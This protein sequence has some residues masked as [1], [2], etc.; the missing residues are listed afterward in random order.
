M[1]ADLNEICS[2]I[3][4]P[5][6]NK[7]TVEQNF[8]LYANQFDWK[9]SVEAKQNGNGRDFAY[10]Q[11]RPGPNPNQIFSLGLNGQ[12]TLFSRLDGASN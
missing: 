12:Q 11:T 4:L 8:R 5:L 3:Y 9:T 7:E 10:L 2:Q 6:C 1:W